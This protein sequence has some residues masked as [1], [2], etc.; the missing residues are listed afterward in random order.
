VRVINK[1]LKDTFAAEPITAQEK[2]NVPVRSDHVNIST[3]SSG[4][5]INLHPSSS[6]SSS[7]TWHWL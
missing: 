6:S 4:N 5:V 3:A 2:E 1:V 7:C